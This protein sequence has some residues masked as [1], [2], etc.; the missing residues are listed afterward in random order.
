MW[1]FIYMFTRS[2]LW[3]TFK[4]LI[5]VVCGHWNCT[6]NTGGGLRVSGQQRPHVRVPMKIC[7]CWNRKTAPDNNN[8]YWK[9]WNTNEKQYYQPAILLPANIHAHKW[10]TVG[11]FR[12]WVIKCACHVL[13]KKRTCRELLSCHSP[14]SRK[15]VLDQYRGTRWIFLYKHDNLKRITVRQL[16][17]LSLVCKILNRFAAPQ[18]QNKLYTKSAHRRTQILH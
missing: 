18:S 5:V 15:D 17:K 6:S 3:L 2:S 7:R 10:P 4:W 14:T 9:Q 1:I 16:I 12:H 11:Y 8:N 13:V